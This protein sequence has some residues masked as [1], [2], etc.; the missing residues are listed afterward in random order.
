[1]G[2]INKCYVLMDLITLL[3]PDSSRATERND[4]SISAGVIDDTIQND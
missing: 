1:M 4:N 3:V 2:L